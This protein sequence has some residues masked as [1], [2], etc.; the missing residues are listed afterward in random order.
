M[1]EDFHFS[2]I[3]LIIV[4]GC[5]HECVLPQFSQ[6]ALKTKKTGESSSDVPRQWSTFFGGIRSTFEILADEI[7][8]ELGSHSN[9]RGGNQSLAETP[10]VNGFAAIC[11]SGI[12]PK[13]LA[14]IFDCLFGS[15]ELLRQGGKSLAG[16]VVK[17]G[18]T[19]MGGQPITFDDLVIEDVDSLRE[20]TDVIFEDDTEKCWIPKV[21]ELLVT[22]LLLR[23]N[24]FVDVLQS[25]PFAKLVEMHPDIEIGDRHSCSSIEDNVF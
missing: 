12:K 25:H 13:N 23:C 14:T 5:N 9:R 1:L 16:W 4:K 15:V 18:N 3:H 22:T 11:R 10:S 2:L 8:E 21:R 20:F 17:N 24:Q 7:N 19:V 6:A